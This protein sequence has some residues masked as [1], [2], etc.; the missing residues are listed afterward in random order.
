MQQIN[1]NF[2]YFGCAITTLYFTFCLFIAFGNFVPLVAEQ[3]LR[4]EKKFDPD[5]QH[6]VAG[7]N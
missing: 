4:L 5:L 3:K 1:L 2:Y 6:Y 7:D